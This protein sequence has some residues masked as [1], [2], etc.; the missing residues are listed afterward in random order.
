MKLTDLIPDP[1]NRRKHTLRNIQM[2]R[3][4]IENVGTG[5]SI[6][7]DEHNEVIAGNATLQAAEQAGLSKVRVVEV[8]GSEVVAVRR[9]GLS[10]KQKRDLALYDNR[11]AELAEWDIEQLA[12]DVNEEL[13]LGEFFE[14]EELQAFSSLASENVIHE[15]SQQTEETAPEV[16]T[17]GPA[18]GYMR[19]SCPLTVEQQLLVHKILNK[20]KKTFSCQATSEALVQVLTQWGSEHGE[21]ET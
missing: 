19:F 9:T 16:Q 18:S 14:S 4:S 5:R 7:I 1:K 20:A 3:E 6:V 21:D 15:L 11:T 12:E 17:I 13:D 10:A 2:L 8:D